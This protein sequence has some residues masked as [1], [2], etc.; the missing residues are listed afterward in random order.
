MRILL[1]AVLLV[2]SLLAGCGERA[3]V[4]VSAGRIDQVLARAPSGDI[5]ALVVYLSDRSGW[6]EADS[7]IVDALVADGAAVIPIDL[8][9]YARNLDADSGGCL[10]VVGE[11]TAIAQNA[12]RALGI[13]TYLPPVLVG[14]GEGA[15]FAYAALADSPANTLGG[16]IGAGFDNHLTLRLPFCPGPTATVLP[17]GGYSYAFDKALPADGHLLV[18]PSALAGVKDAAAAQPRLDVEPLSDAA[19]G[20]QITSLLKSLDATAGFAGLP[21]VSIKPQGTPRGLVVFFSGDG[22]W[23][24]LDKTMGEWMA[25]QGYEVL[26]FDALRYFW[27][28]KKPEQIASDIQTVVTAAD[29]TSQLPVLLVGY[30]FG[31]DTVPF[32]WPKLPAALRDRI[33][34]VALLAPSLETGFQVSVAGWLGMSGGSNEVV[35]AIAAMPADKVLCVY[36][37]DEKDAACT[38]PA[39]ADVK[40]IVTKGGHHFDG[41][42][43][44]L[45]KRVLDAF[46]GGKA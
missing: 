33:R 30:S 8:S 4:P 43:E 36:G 19:P 46:L 22:G 15:T 17:G 13:E 9:Q 6:Q 40:T 45:G 25:T 38:N 27:A 14:R 26:G 29:P 1:I 31:A 7:D 32:A 2:T 10:Y 3:V 41:D 23:R 37:A 21:V 12:Q 35:P 34:L 11:L 44:A 5:S 42:Y 24:D 16:A 39:L 20:E 18:A 28:E